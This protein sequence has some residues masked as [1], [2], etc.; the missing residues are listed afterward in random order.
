MYLDSFENP[1]YVKPPNEDII[2]CVLRV[3]STMGVLQTWHI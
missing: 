1:E 3:F 2:G